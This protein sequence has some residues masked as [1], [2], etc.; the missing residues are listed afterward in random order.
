MADQE[1]TQETDDT[2]PNLTIAYIIFEIFILVTLLPVGF[3][4][5]RSRKSNRSREAKRTQHLMV[6]VFLCNA[7][8]QVISII[9]YSVC[10]HCN[11]LY[12]VW[13]VCRC[14]MLGINWI[15]LIHRAKLVQGMSPVLDAVWFEKI[16]PATLALVM[17]GFIVNSIRLCM[18]SEF[19]CRP[20]SDNNTL[21]FCWLEDGQDGFK[22]RDVVSAW[23]GITWSI[24][25][26]SFLILLF[27]IPLYRVYQVDLGR[28]N[29]N[30]LRQRKKLKSLLIWSVILT[31]INQV[32]STAI[33]IVIAVDVIQYPMLFMLVFST[34]KFDPSINVWSSWM[35]VGRNRRYRDAVHVGVQWRNLCSRVH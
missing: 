1:S 20:Y 23:V 13:S 12:A 15:F 5:L 18:L 16:L 14:L 31:F 33:L 27:V 11:T 24:A 26:T 17:L 7:V 19:T 22:E 3:L 21:Q 2:Y 25:W 30:Q 34:G 9:N 32:S 10:S 28:M 8:Y 35:M 4:D 6:G 29:A